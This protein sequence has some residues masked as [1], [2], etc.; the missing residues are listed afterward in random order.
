MPVGSIGP[1][2][3]RCLARLRKLLA[4]VV[5][6]EE[7]AAVDSPGR[8]TPADLSD[9]DLVGLLRS[10]HAMADPIASDVLEQSRRLLET[11]RRTDTPE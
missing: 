10:S 4:V 7:G 5:A 8:F 9:A 2:R 3:A 11:A 1:T 6:P